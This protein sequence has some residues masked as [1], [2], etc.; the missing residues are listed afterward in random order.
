[1]RALS[2]TVTDTP[3]KFT[4]TGPPTTVLDDEA[5]RV[6]SPLWKTYVTG[7][8]V[9]DAEPSAKTNPKSPVN[10]QARMP[11]TPFSFDRPI[12]AR[13]SLAPRAPRPLPTEAPALE[14]A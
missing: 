8:A 4:F 14:P 9:A 13:L 1:V 10:D 12:G 11:T 2:S 3:V 7:V 5:T 6:T